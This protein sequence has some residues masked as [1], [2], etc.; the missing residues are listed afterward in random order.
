MEIDRYIN[1]AP[2]TP[3]ADW[4]RQEYDRFIALIE[5]RR[6]EHP[7]PVNSPF[8]GNIGGDAWYYLTQEEGNQYAVACGQVAYQERVLARERRDAKR[9]ERLR[10]LGAP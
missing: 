9:A 4:F 2:G 1:H 3:E 10:L 7:R 5:D 8:A 6:Q